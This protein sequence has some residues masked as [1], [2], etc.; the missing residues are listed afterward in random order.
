[1]TE[2]KEQYAAF[3]TWAIVEIMGH[4][5]Y[6]G[7]VT[8]QTIAGSSFL[9]V[10]IPAVNEQPEFTKLFSPAS[11]YAITPV[12][13]EIA[14]GVAQGCRQ[15]PISIYDLPQEMQ[16]KLRPRITQASMFDEDDDEPF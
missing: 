9:R 8:E 4:Q 1:M 5:R 13:E 2:T 15:A 11:V 12:T 14:K 7:R 3:E 6:A 10:D 16:D